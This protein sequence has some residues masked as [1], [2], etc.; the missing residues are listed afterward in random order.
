M[1]TAFSV[2]ADDICL[3]GIWNS[4]LSWDYLK[5][6]CAVSGDENLCGRLALRTMYISRVPT[7]SVPEADR[8]PITALMQTCLDSN[9]VGCEAWER[10]IA[11]RFANR[12]V[13]SYTFKNK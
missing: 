7:Q 13:R 6:K 4:T 8:A 2:P 10:E 12:K 11:A 5:G 1:E 3:H 9:G